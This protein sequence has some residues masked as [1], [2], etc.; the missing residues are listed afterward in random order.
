MNESPEVFTCNL[1][2]PWYLST[3][4]ICV[5]FAAWFIY[6]IPVLLGIVLLINRAKYEKKAIAQVQDLSKRY[7]DAQSL[8]TPEMQDAHKLQLLVNSLHEEESS[9]HK[10]LDEMKAEAEKAIA[11]KQTGLNSIEKQIA[12]KKKQLICM[13][14]EILVQEFGLYTPQ[15]DFASALD[16]KEELAKIRQVQKDLIK[17]KGAVLG[18]TEWTVNNSKAKGKQMVSDTQKLLLRAF[19]T[20]CDDLI[21]RVKYN[22]F[23]ATLDRIYKSAETITKLG[24]VMN[25]SISQKYLDAKVKE[26]RLAFEYRE[27][28]QQEKEEQKMARAEQREQ[29]KIQREIEEQRKKIEKEQT[30][31]QTAYEKLKLQ[32]EQNP[33]DK[34]LLEKKEQLENHLSDIDKA[35]CDIDYRQ[36][37]M[38]AGYVYIISNIGA[39]GKDIYKIG[40]TRR[41]DPQ[42]R[43]DELGD[44]SVPFNFDVHAMI[45][46]DDAP[47]LEAALHRAFEDR[48]LNMVNQR[49]EFFNVTLDEIKEVIKKNFDKTVEFVDVP[50]AEQ[51]RISQ[52]MRSKMQHT[53]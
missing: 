13:D 43:V 1:K 20:E 46:S 10:N 38:R 30:H 7:A 25:I 3:P 49:R 14:D 16:Y 32:L 53:A 5:L 6:G 2:A 9:A 48:K 27:K 40:M 50:D 41:L 28:K 36:A 11:K 33:E 22:N 39:F 4:L 17:E 23:N 44:A 51:Y 21:N 15:Y 31:Y 47:A 18:N 37:N 34:N 45:F 12:E 29:A 8:L 19:N 26:L 42:D 52:K 35:L 24:S